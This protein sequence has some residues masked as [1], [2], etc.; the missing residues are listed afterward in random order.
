MSEFR[1]PEDRVDT[2]AGRGVAIESRTAGLRKV[3][4]CVTRKISDETIVVPIRAN[5]A[6]LDSVYVL[7][8]VGAAIWSHLDR[9]LAPAEIAAAVADEYEVSP[10]IA[11]EDVD[12]FLRALLGAGV[13]EGQVG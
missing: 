7:N 3:G 6:E 8:E 5:A 10:E 1:P 12:R 13:V 9:G 2:E 4:N 11:R